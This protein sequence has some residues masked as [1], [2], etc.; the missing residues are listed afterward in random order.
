MK[1]ILVCVDY[2]DVTDRVVSSAL[3]WAAG[4]KADVHLFHVIPPSPPEIFYASPGG[5]YPVATAVQT[6]TRKERA[7]LKALC[8]RL[9]RRGVEVSEEVVE[10]RVIDEI[11]AAAER[12][13]AECIVLGSHGHGALYELLV[14][15]VTEGVLHRTRRPVWV[16][17]GQAQG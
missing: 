7:K 15:S 11:L 12:I 1:R 10:G 2:S 9:P 8:A 13:E 14:G 3:R 16:V 6:D 17:P 4:L 5:G